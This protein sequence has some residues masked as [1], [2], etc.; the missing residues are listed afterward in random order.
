MSNR[1]KPTK[2]KLLEGNLG[3]RPLNMNEPEPL[4]V[5][6][7]CPSWF[8]NEAKE[9]PEYERQCFENYLKNKE[10]EKEVESKKVSEEV[11]G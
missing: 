1:P 5:K 9:N 4:K 2:L 11:S 7:G 8:D 10:E 6:L 3:K